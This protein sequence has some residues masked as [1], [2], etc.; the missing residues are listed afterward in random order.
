M[1]D[2]WLPYRIL[3]RTEILLHALPFSCIDKAAGN[4]LTYFLLCIFG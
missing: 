2:I 1:N 4:T 3:S